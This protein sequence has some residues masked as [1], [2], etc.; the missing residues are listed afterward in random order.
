MGAYAAF[1]T[2]VVI[3]YRSLMAL[4]RYGPYGAPFYQGAGMVFW[5]TAVFNMDHNYLG[6][7]LI[8]SKIL[9]LLPVGNTFFIAPYFIVQFPYIGF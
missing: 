6:Y 1:Y 4:L 2:L 5:T 9:K 8:N 7:Y 3:Y